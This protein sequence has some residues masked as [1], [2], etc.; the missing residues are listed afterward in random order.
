MGNGNVTIVIESS[1]GVDRDKKVCTRI[2]D[3]DYMTQEFLITIP[4]YIWK[5]VKCDS[6]SREAEIVQ[7]KMVIFEK[8]VIRVICI[9]H[10]FSLLHCY[11]RS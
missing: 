7:D 11:E 6:P 2:S 8:M 10:Y 5:V 9:C 3:K 4:F 1:N